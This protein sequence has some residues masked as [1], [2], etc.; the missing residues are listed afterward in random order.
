MELEKDVKVPIKYIYSALP[1]G[2]GPGYSIESVYGMCES[3]WM[4]TVK[5]I[6]EL[7]EE[8]A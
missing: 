4:D 6:C 8:A 1:D 3:A 2:A 7:K 5:E